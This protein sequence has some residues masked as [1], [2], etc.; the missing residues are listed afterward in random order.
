MIKKSL[1]NENLNDK[2]VIYTGKNGGVELRADTDKETIWATQDQIADLFE[3]TK[4]N[5]GQHLK[6]IF[7]TNELAQN[8][9]VKDF[10]TTAADGKQYKVN[11]YNLDAIIAV[12]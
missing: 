5:V 2:L 3:T 12:G 9:A 7:L 4:Q 8:S 6:S 1:N 11:F 10:F